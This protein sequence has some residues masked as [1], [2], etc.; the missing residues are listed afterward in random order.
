MCK[1]CKESFKL[2]TDLKIH[3]SNH[4]NTMKTESNENY[5]LPELSTDKKSL[6]EDEKVKDVFDEICEQDVDD[7]DLKMEFKTKQS[8]MK[9]TDCVD[10]Y[11]ET[12][13]NKN[14]SDPI[15]DN[16]SILSNMKTNVDIADNKSE[17]D[18]EDNELK[19]ELDN[20]IFDKT[21]DK[22]LKKLNE[23]LKQNY[24]AE[25]HYK[26]EEKI[27]H[28]KGLMNKECMDNK[29]SKS[30]DC[31]IFDKTF[32]NKSALK[33]HEQL[34]SEKKQFQCDI[35]NK[36]FKQKVTLTNHKRYVN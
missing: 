33:V 24:S 35:C 23:D 25:N 36:S 32:S 1:T 15:N 26:V 3:E 14:N 17:I 30:F 29:Q 5:E 9:S 2:R 21:A 16:N 34:H 10:R 12:K 11:F 27:L 18:L 4:A 28:S 7:N 22:L 19:V 8:I 13:N 31:S 6:L 20:L